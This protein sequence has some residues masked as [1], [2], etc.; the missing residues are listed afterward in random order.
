MTIYFRKGEFQSLIIH[1][2]HF[3][4]DFFNPQLLK[5]LP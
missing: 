1:Q 3:F 5:E 2:G 4:F